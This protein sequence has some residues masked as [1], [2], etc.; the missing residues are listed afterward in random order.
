MSTP[1]V[2]LF[3]KNA[4]EAEDLSDMLHVLRGWQVVRCRD[5]LTVTEVAEA[6]ASSLVLAFLSAPLADLHSSGIL[7]VLR[8]AGA[9]IV[10]LDLDA[11]AAKALGVFALERPFVDGQVQALLDLMQG[12]IEA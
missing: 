11:A 5:I 9:R 3:T 6:V 2:L 7:E 4:V 12:E 10:V 1:E 8:K